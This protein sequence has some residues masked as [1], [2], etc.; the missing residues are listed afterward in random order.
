MTELLFFFKKK[1]L[2]S[3]HMCN[4]RCRVDGRIPYVLPWRQEPLLSH[5]FSRN[6]TPSTRP[7]WSLFP[8]YKPPCDALNAQ[9]APRIQ[10]RNATPHLIVVCQPR[11][12][13]PLLQTAAINLNLGEGLGSDLILA[14]QRSAVPPVPSRRLQAVSVAF[15]AGRPG[16][17]FL[18]ID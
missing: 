13:S 8:L 5:F 18:A 14:T 2:S 16:L 3:S 15:S 12:V 10:L 1:S 7:A 4:S 11:I 9:G 17:L 6:P